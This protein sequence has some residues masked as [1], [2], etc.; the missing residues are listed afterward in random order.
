MRTL[1][2][3]SL[4]LGQNVFSVSAQDHSE[5]LPAVKPTATNSVP[6]LCTRTFSNMSQA[7]ALYAV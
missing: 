5:H 4:L 1:F 7:A 3:L 2:F 6:A